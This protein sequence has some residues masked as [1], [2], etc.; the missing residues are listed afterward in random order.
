MNISSWSIR[1]PVPAVLVFILLTVFGLIGF[2]KLQ[3]QDFPDTDLPTVT[4]TATLEG[5]APSQLETE[6]ARKIEDKLASLTRLDHITTTITDG[7]V[8]LSVSFT[9]D[10]DSE[11]AVNEV[12]N[13]V[14]SARGDL[15]SSMNAPTVTK[16][17][18][19]NASLM[20]YVIDSER[21]D[22]SDLSWFVDNDATKAL[23]AVPGVASIKRLGGI[24]RE[25][26]ID[27][28][29]VAMAGLGVTPSDVSDRLKAVQRESS[30]GQGHIGGQRQ[31]ARMIA[32]AE[33]VDE[34]RQIALPLSDGRW[35][36]LDQIARVTDG[37]AD[38]ESKALHKDKEVLGLQVTRSLGYSDVGVARDVRAAMDKFARDNPQVTIR[39]VSN[40]IEPVIDNYHGSLELLLEG[41]VLAII[42]VWW[43]LRDWR[44]TLIAAV[45]LPLSIL[46]TFAFMWLAGYSL[47]MVT[48][49]SL[50]LVVG[51][52]VDDAIVEVENIERHLLMGKRPFEAAMEAADEIG[53]AVIA[54][55]FTLV[56]VFLPTAFMGGIPG[57][58]FRQF[59]VTA[60]VAVLASLLVA[61][62]LTPM[63]AAY[64]LK[65]RNAED[66]RGRED[67]PIMR[68]YLHLAASAMRRRKT[69]ILS[70]LLF[71]VLCLGLAAFIPTAFMPAQDKAQ[72]TITLQVAPGSTLQDTTDMA[73]RAATLLRALPE[74]KDVFA[75]A[76]SASS[77]GMGGTTTADLTSATLTIDLVP[78]TERHATQS[79]V[80]A[81]MRARLRTLPG[82]RV[83]VG[84]GNSG[85]A[86]EL[87]L[88][89]D[90][91][92][93]L[94][95]AASQV[96]AGLR[97]L[98]GIGNVTSSASLQR[99]E[100]QVRPNH[101][102]AAH[103]GVTSEALGDAL[104]FATYGD[105][106]TA[107]PKLNLPQR[108]INIR[109][110]MSPELRQDL[111][112]VGQLRVQGRD[113]LVSLASVADIG[114][115]SG[116][117][118]IDRI[119][120]LR[121]VTLTVELNGRAIGEVEREAR[122]L[123]AMQAL[124]ESVKQVDQG[125]LQRM[126]ELFQSFGLAMAI[127]VFC[128]YAV[129]VLLF[130]DF[131]QPATILSALPL[132]LAGAL[133]ALWAAEQAFSMPVV[134][135]VLMLMG[136]V[137][138]N[139][140]LLV[141]YAI[142]SRRK[143]MARFDALMDACHKRA[144]PIVMT[145]IAMGGG[146]LPNA[147]GLGAE[148]SFRQPMAIVVI[149]GL[150]TSTV[151]SLVVVPVVFTYV[152]DLLQW[153]KKRLLPTRH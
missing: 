66:G 18:A 28:D 79:Q 120:R 32:T 145:T 33:S 97:T 87:T 144:R 98:S 129:L 12:R 103:L 40:T 50:A 7:S 39:E 74:V 130:H 125:E 146:M 81:Q 36:R 60:S 53:M 93:A 46:P 80:E 76:G 86:L 70:A 25:V 63:M 92:E 141:E 22:E 57:K 78:R 82:L 30:G 14:D 121:K 150:I 139:S 85:E 91:P 107:L 89:S 24:D 112:A 106:S 44:A 64:L 124:P 55:T 4:V 26:I 77:G 84:G 29:P 61:R 59:G 72:T 113:G 135:G 153:L 27:L 9:L 128:I 65:P 23:L 137:T 134:I 21:L 71:F 67:G 148:P 19:A 62:L 16:Q 88:A 136:I 151:L 142:V 43:F 140:I 132:A 20:T 119:D 96:E 90:D 105:Y 122:A 1:N 143:G 15:P 51:I 45:A 104:R 123:P 73:E 49:L 114:I 10:K 75:L 68:R 2:S 48:L 31:S 100:I 126:S 6:V 152:D 118:Q 34:V 95:R 52:L 111:N 3:I 99:P 47:N 5:A 109:A 131:M 8:V 38:R 116:P 133:F 41:A 117:S 13:A 147:L 110:R 149:G 69:T 127:G 102:A 108:Q 54:T 58:F 94:N 138:K 42:V 35:V 37:H 83:A 56:A 17:T 11:V 115:G 101:A